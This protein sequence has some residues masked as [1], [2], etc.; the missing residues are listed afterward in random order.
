M[1]SNLEQ[2]KHSPVIA[3]LRTPPEDKVFNIVEALLEGGITNL[4]LTMQQ[5]DSADMLAELNR[6]YGDRAWIGAGT[7]MDEVT[8]VNAIHA[9]ASFIFSPN[10][11]E[12]VV[13]AAKRYGVIS[14]PGV[15]TPSEMVQ[16]VEQGADCVKIFPASAF[17]PRYIKELKGPFPQIP[18]IPTGGIS[19][20]NIQEYWNAGAIACGMGSSLLDKQAIENS[21]F[22]ELTKRAKRIMSKLK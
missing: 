2:L 22:S 11:N 12:K 17:G 3:V 20:E 9:G 5:P 14:I 7:V 1:G 16:A 8:A 10:Y 21:Q 19:E 13:K 6:R 18:V 15:L 4:E